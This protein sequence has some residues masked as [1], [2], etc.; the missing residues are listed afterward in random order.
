MAYSRSK[1]MKL[2]GIQPLK[3][4]GHITSKIVKVNNSLRIELD[5]RGTLI[6]QINGLIN[7]L[8]KIYIHLREIFGHFGG[9]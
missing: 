8:Q 4:H 9:N 7:I 3:V 1:Y 2:N 6:S 5:N